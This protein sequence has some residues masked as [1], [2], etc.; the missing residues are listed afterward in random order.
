MSAYKSITCGGAVIGKKLKNPKKYTVTYISSKSYGSCKKTSSS[1]S[2][3]CC[4]PCNP[5]YII[6]VKESDGSCGIDLNICPPECLVKDTC[7]CSLY[8]TLKSC[9]IA[10][11]IDLLLD[12]ALDEPSYDTLLSI[13]NA[14]VTNITDSR[15]V[16]TLPDGT[17]VIDTFFGAGNT[18][19]NYKNKVIN[20]NHNSRVAILNAQQCEGG[21]GYERKFSSTTDRPEKYVAIRLGKYLNNAGTIRLSVE[22]CEHEI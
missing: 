20:E 6:Y 11:R 21:V 18:W 12:Q 17:V 3:G 19:T 9:I 1:C 15:A 4:D 8:S 16:V 7:Y 10:H 2:C 22:T 5:P 14:T 13:I